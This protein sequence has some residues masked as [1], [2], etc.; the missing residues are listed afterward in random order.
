MVTKETYLTE[1]LVHKIYKFG[2][3]VYKVPK[4]TFED[5][6]NFEHF[7][8]EKQSHEILRRNG[9][10]AVEVEDI[11]YN[12]GKYILKE[13]FI[14]GKVID[15]PN[16]SVEQKREILKVCLIGNKI[17]ISQYGNFST[18]GI[19]K[20]SGW[21]EYLKYTI[22]SFAKVRLKEIRPYLDSLYD[23][24]NN[25]PD[26]QQGYFLFLDVNSNNFIFDDN[27]RIIGIIDIDHPI[28][29]DPIYD[30]AALRWH[31]PDLYEILCNEFREIDEKEKNI[32][33]KYYI[34]FGVSTLLFEYNHGLDIS[35][36]LE[37]LNE[38]KI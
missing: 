11:Y 27:D 8:I 28:S 17:P 25:F 32:I 16:L 5:F 20:F 12:D 18:K 4:N 36:S 22:K 6:N 15:N 29:G 37:K 26:I 10:P 30:Y 2:D 1:G 33:Q 7:Q 24:Q 34:H 38:T 23:F 31:H 3:S 13:K 35:N 21:N 19:G 14:A 9:L